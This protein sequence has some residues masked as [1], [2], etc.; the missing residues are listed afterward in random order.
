MINV[1]DKVKVT[2]SGQCYSAYDVWI[3]VNFPEYHD[4]FAGRALSVGTQ[5]KVV[6]KALHERKE[7]GMLYLIQK[8]DGNVFIM[9]E[10]GIEKMAEE[11]FQPK[12]GMIAVCDD[13]EERLIL[14]FKG[15][16]ILA[17]KN[18]WRPAESINTGSNKVLA[19]KQPS[20]NMDMC[21]FLEGN[22]YVATTI[23]EEENEEKRELREVIDKLQAE[24]KDA[25]EKLNSL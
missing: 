21:L 10:E 23:F 1:G 3:K 15:K 20:T 7:E 19:Y 4:K 22:E 25:Q 2:R 6:G 24:L 5:G 18:D 14:E 13:G 12:S 16:L 8:D 11:K 17:G 9:G